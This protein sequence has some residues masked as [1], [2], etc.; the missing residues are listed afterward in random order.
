M[1]CGLIFARNHHSKVF[2]GLLVGS[3]HISFFTIL[4]TSHKTFTF[5]S[6]KA[7]G[8]ILVNLSQNTLILYNPF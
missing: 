1:P 7:Y 5:K 8:I 4:L 6:I 3:F 2:A